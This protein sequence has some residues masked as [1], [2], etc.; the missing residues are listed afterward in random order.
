MIN[1]YKVLNGIQLSIL[2]IMI[3]ILAGCKSM[4]SHWHK[5]VDKEIGNV[6]EESAEIVAHEIDVP[7][8]VSQ[9]MLLPMDLKVPDRKSV[10]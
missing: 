3:L 1:K 9:S 2:L 4:P 10:V 8:E 5:S 7:P 6:L